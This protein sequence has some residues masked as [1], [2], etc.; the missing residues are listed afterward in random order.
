MRKKF[1]GCAN[2]D[3]PGTREHLVCHRQ[4]ILRTSIVDQ[5]TVVFGIVFKSQK[6]LFSMKYAEN[7][8]SEY[9]KFGLRLL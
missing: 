5:K 9:F 3:M 6:W 2:I 1:P 8:L 4:Y 7:N